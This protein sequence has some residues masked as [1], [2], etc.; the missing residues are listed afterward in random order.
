MVIDLCPVG[1]VALP[2]AQPAL[3][4][5]GVGEFCS[6]G[7]VTTGGC[8]APGGA[9]GSVGGVSVAAGGVS[10]TGASV[11]VPVGADAP[12]LPLVSTPATG[13]GPSVLPVGVPAALSSASGIVAALS[14]AGVTGPGFCRL[15]P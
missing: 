10:V 4:V 5:I 1:G 15:A 14:S 11:P 12:S 6:P 2:F 13:G 8:S 3:G 7:V 9:S